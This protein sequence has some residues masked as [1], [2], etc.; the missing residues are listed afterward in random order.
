MSVEQEI[1]RG[2][3]NFAKQ[4]NILLNDD[5]LAEFMCD[6]YKRRRIL[7][8]KDTYLITCG[9]LKISEIITL[10]TLCKEY[11]NYYKFVWGIIQHR[12]YPKS[13]IP[14]IDYVSIR[15]NIAIDKWQVQLIR[16][17]INNKVPYTVFNNSNQYNELIEDDETIQQRSRAL[18]K[19]TSSHIGYIWRKNTHLAEIKAVKETRMCSFD[20]CSQDICKIINDFKFIS[21]TDYNNDPYYTIKKKID[22]RLYGFIPKKKVDWKKWEDGM[23]WVAG[24]YTSDFDYEYDMTEVIDNDTYYYGYDSDGDSFRSRIRPDWV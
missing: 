1:Q 17:K 8:S 9:Y 6:T 20:K 18:E 5:Q 4:Y 14:V 23:K 16:L 7:L 19:L 3:I 12:Y 24:E 21:E 11:M 15:Q 13:I 22:M 2:V 10:T